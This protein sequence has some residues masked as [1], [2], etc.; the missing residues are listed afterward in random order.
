ML[1]EDR[2]FLYEIDEPFM[3]VMRVYNMSKPY[4]PKLRKSH[5]SA[6]NNLFFVA[7][8]TADWCDENTRIVCE[9]F[10]AEVLIGNRDNTHLNKA[11]Y[12]NVMEKFK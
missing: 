8:S 3:F 2:L 12:K 10:A 4:M 6:Y 9:L 7:N 1:E 5:T 11:G